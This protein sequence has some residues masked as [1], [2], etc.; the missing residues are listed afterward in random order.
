MEGYQTPQSPL[1]VNDPRRHA[2]WD[3]YITLITTLLPTLRSGR[4]SRPGELA[5]AW[6]QLASAVDAAGSEQAKRILSGLPP[7]PTADDLAP[8]TEEL[9][10]I[11]NV[12]RR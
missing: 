3:G 7:Q 9:S 12:S 10:R 2:A 4:E 11:A 5:T 8:L 1:A 6:K